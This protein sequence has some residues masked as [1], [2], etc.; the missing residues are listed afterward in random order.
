MYTF[1]VETPT[2]VAGIAT[3]TSIALSWNSDSRVV[4]YDLMWETNDIGGC[5]G[6]S[7]SNSISI[8]DSSST[9]YVIM[10]LEENSEYI[11]TLKVSNS[12][13][14]SAVDN[15]TALTLEVGEKILILCTINI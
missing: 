6:S 15:V 8:T 7:D 5:S 4:S 1:T 14:S 3:A 9:S 11:I 12:A 10:G 2:L 13:G